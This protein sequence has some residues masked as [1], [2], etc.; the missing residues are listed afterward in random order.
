MTSSPAV[1]EPEPVTQPAVAVTEVRV[2]E[3]P[4]LY[5]AKPAIKVSLVLPGYLAADERTL[6]ELATRVGA[7][8]AVA[9]SSCTTG[10]HLAL[11]VL[12]I[13]PGDEV[14]VPSL[15]FMATTSVVRYVGATPVFADV[16]PVTANV[17]LGTIEAVASP[18]TRG[19]AWSL[20]K[21]S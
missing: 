14:V 11:V 10:L 7:R 8:H 5:F 15:S 9:V 1:S 3:G 13:G 17:T 6:T 12:G 21:L 16:D 18:R 4:N 19:I 20:R 2:L